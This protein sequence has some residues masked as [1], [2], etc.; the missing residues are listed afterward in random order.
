V[1]PWRKSLQSLGIR[2]PNDWE[3][4]MGYP[5][6]WTNPDDTRSETLSS[7]GLPNSFSAA[8]NL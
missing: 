2:H 1:G 8:S 4:M 6:N 7:L 5:K 3:R